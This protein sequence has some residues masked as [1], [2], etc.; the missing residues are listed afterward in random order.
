MSKAVAESKG[1]ELAVSTDADVWGNV[2][3]ES[4]DFIMPRILLQQAMSEAVKERVA[5]DG[6]YLNTLTSSVCSN[7]D[8]E[9]NIL[10]FLCKQSYTVEKWNGSKFVYD[11]VDPYVEGVE[12]KWEENINGIRYKVIHC[13]NFFCLLEEGG[14]PAIVPFKSTSHKTGQRLFNLM[15]VS[16]RQQTPAFPKGKTPAH[17]WITLGRKQDSN[18]D[19]DKYYVSEIELGRESTQEELKECLPWI[20]VINSANYKEADEKAPSQTTTT[21]TRF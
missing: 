7:K 15:Y 1:T 11:H 9:I 13:Y 10:P 6:D 17:N 12:R 5:N 2:V 20:K 4:K 14:L 21:E 8:G 19:G 16:N 18:K 3:V